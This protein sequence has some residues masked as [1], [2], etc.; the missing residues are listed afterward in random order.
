MANFFSFTLGRG[1]FNLNGVRYPETYGTVPGFGKQ[2]FLFGTGN[3]LP[4]PATVVGTLTVSNLPAASLGVTF[5]LLYEIFERGNVV[6][7]GCQLLKAGMSQTKIAFEWENV[8]DTPGTGRSAR[9]QRTEVC[10]GL[11][12][13]AC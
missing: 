10:Q 4:N 12:T 9:R 6:Y 8:E 2:G 5:Y 7:R 13:W 3:R 11:L 1:V